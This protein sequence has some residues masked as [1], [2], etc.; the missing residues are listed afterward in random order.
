MGMRIDGAPQFNEGK[1]KTW[2]GK[3]ATWV[4]IFLYLIVILFQVEPKLHC[5]PGCSNAVVFKNTFGRWLLPP[6]P[7]KHAAKPPQARMLIVR[8]AGCKPKGPKLLGADKWQLGIQSIY[9]EFVWC[10]EMLI[11]GYR[12]KQLLDPQK[13]LI[14]ASLLRLL[15]TFHPNEVQSQ[16]VLKERSFE[17]GSCIPSLLVCHHG[18]PAGHRSSSLRQLFSMQK[19][20]SMC[21]YWKY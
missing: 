14:Q 20:R 3:R 11:A 2:N 12:K 19:F 15:S 17:A 8:P 4:M 7:I 10:F 9:K 5:K 1:E 6:Y 13:F 21:K 18:L 16:H